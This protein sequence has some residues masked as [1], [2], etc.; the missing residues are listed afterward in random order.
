MT[1]TSDRVRTYL[2]QALGPVV[3]V[4][5]GRDLVGSQSAPCAIAT[6][7]DQPVEGAFTLVT[8]GLSDSPL[9]GPEGE[10]VRQELLLC[11]WNADLDDRLYGL[12][13]TVAT[14]IRD[15]GETANP[16]AVLE[17]DGPLGEPG[18]LRHVFLYPPTYHRDELATISAPDD[19]GSC[20]EIEILWLLPV[21]AVEVEL[22]EAQGPEAFEAH[23][24]EA[25]PDL[26]DLRRA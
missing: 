13:F 12:L 17:L 23:L 21:T 25:D 22:I 11:G 8:L 6:F 16:G 2:E 15:A 19:D 26:L 3:R 4:T 5:T 20:G 9:L 18:D 14:G 10:R 7:A 1:T 24:V